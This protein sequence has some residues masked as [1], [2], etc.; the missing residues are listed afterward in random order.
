MKITALL[1]LLL[2]VSPVFAAPFA[3]GSIVPRFVDTSVVNQQFIYSIPSHNET[4]TFLRINSTNSTAG[5][6]FTTITDVLLNSSSCRVA[7]QACDG[8]NVVVY[9][10]GIDITFAGP[11]P[12]VPS[13]TTITV[14]FNATTPSSYNTTNFTAYVTSSTGT[15]LV[16]PSSFGTTFVTTQQMI[17][18]SSVSIVKGSAVVNGSD[19]WEFRFALA[20]NA[21]VT[22]VIQYKMNNWTDSLGR[23]MSTALGNGTSYATLRNNSGN[24]TDPNGKFDIYNDYVSNVGINRTAGQKLQ[25]SG[26]TDYAYLRMYIP[27]GVVTSSTWSTGYSFLFR[28]APL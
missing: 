18:V 10:S 14:L 23:V 1:A 8:S 7:G 5:F 3:N 24:F 11:V 25:V 4:I 15:S 26:A 12:G 28:S 22:G 19:F 17:N 16:T 27:A 2:F 21:D 20:F 9:P 13:T 6:I